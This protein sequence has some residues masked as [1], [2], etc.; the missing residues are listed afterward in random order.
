M[1]SYKK[2]KVLITTAK[3]V[4]AARVPGP[5]SLWQS[6][7]S[8]SHSSAQPLSGDFKELSKLAATGAVLHKWGLW[9]RAGQDTFVSSPDILHGLCSAK[10]LRV[11]TWEFSE[12][13][14]VSVT[15][16]S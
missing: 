4:V 11:P 8:C 2:L 15:V 1:N 13:M 6:G 5:S 10:I 9:Q 3:N 7:L 14:P 16:L 12:R